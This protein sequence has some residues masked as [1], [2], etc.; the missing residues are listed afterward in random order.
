MTQ[1][2]KRG[3]KISALDIK[4][5]RKALEWAVQG[6]E[7]EIN[8]LEIEMHIQSIY[9]DKI[10]TEEIQKSLIDIALKLTTAERPEWRM[11]AARLLVMEVYKEAGINRKYKEFGYGNY[12]EFVKNAV[13]K[14]LYD[15]KILKE[16]SDKEIEKAG[17]Y[18]NPNYD[19]DFDYAGINMIVK[20]YLLQDRGKVF[21]LPQEMFM[22]I[23]LLIASIEPKEVRLNSAFEI[24]DAIASRKIS[25][26][27]PILINLRRNSGNLS[28]CF[29]S[30]VDDS[31]DS[32][33]YNIESIA[34]ISKNGGG[35]GVNLSRIRA[36]GSEINGTLNASGGVIPWIKI[37]NDTAVA[38]NQLGKR[39]GAVTAA[40]DIWH[41]DIED[42][43]E[44]Q[45]ENGDQRK[46][47]Y[48]IFP[49]IVIPDLF[50]QR[51]LEDKKWTIFDP[52]EVRLVYGIEIAE[53][54]GRE[55]EEI[56]L[57]IENDNKIVLKK[58]IS[59]KE[60][61]KKIMKTQIETGM[62]YLFF[63]DS[64]NRNN[65]NQ[66]DG[67][68]G[69]GNLCQ[70]SF[71]NF[72][73]SKLAKK[74]YNII[75]DMVE[76]DISSGTVHTCNLVSLNLAI[77]LEDSEIEK[78][79]KLAV[80]ILDNSIDLTESPIPESFKHNLIYRT[81]GVGA[82]G[83]ADYLAY[84]KIAYASEK[85]IKTADRIFELIA[86][87]ALES[88]CELAKIR[89]AYPKFKGSQWDKDIYFGRDLDD[90]I[91]GGDLNNRW[92]NLSI[93]IKKY[94]IRN[95][96]LLAIAPNTSS[97]LVQG[98]S[99]SILPVYSKF[100]IDKNSKGAVPICPPYIKEGFWYYQENKNINQK[101]VVD[102]ISAVQKWVDQ[103][104]S[105]EFIYNLNMDI[106]AKDIYDTIFY[107]WEKGCKTIYYTRT[108]QKSSDILSSKEECVSCAN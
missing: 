75:K 80:K 106:K 45:T 15:E 28:S 58:E 17:K 1:I 24:Y 66:H 61:L 95:G 47:A 19:L 85:S 36:K 3:N 101:A 21:E 32:I 26:A 10:T 64:V 53:K 74:S 33:F 14:S 69:N 39:A 52:N 40:L 98:C 57:N 99:A 44:L 51:V 13:K 29:I 76:S 18:I 102:V 34:Q 16:Y 30:A 96:Q 49:Q 54:W 23:A 43:L 9:T 65:P 73:P 107:T 71:S 55:F 91:D 12:L 46:K 63:K 79:A 60:L 8:F 89:G 56:Y 37:I 86:I 100:Y 35:V 48:D 7:G 82:M 94:G 88:S 81:I 108:I 92:E 4:E 97:A 70:E 105:F 62:P 25:L 5:I 103:G 68:I 6:L 2:I 83:F 59:S 87:S 20:R 50:M 41:L 67:L 104:I 22:T 11:L 72:S 38:V 77:L 31:L 42:F 84:N 27:T 78:A 93:N 90:I